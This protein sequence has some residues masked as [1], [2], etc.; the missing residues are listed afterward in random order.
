MHSR[1]YSQ[2]LIPP[3]R[4]SKKRRNRAGL[5]GFFSVVQQVNLLCLLLGTDDSGIGSTRISN[6]VQLNITEGL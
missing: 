2:I 3:Q 4:R 5:H 6:T 1:R